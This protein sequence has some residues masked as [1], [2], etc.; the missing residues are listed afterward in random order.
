LKITGDYK[1]SRYLILN[2]GRIIAQ[3]AT[4]AEYRQAFDLLFRLEMRLDRSEVFCDC[5]DI[6]QPNN[7]GWRQ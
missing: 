4:Y 7:S 3:Y 2:K 1:E 5:K 6:G